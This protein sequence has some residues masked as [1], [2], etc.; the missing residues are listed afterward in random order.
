MQ[1]VGNFFGADVELTCQETVSFLRDNLLNLHVN[2]VTMDTKLTLSM[3]KN[4]IEQAKKY[5]RRKNTSLSNL[6]EN[7][8]VSVTKNSDEGESTISPLVKSLSGV[9]KLDKKAN[10]K[11]QYTDFL[12]KK[13]K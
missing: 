1:D 8:L 7:Y 9:I 10:P 2:V 5:A 6:I 11:K 4:I 3:D 12:A 13:Y